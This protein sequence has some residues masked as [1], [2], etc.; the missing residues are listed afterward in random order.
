MKKEELLK[1]LKEL[2]GEGDTEAAHSIAD[3]LLIE[4]INDPDITE[5][6][7]AIDKWYA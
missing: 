2:Q 5:A 4:F 7:E 1:R 6:Y 3:N